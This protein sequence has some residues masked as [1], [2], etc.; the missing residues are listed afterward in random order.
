MAKQI[1]VDDMEGFIAALKYSQTLVNTANSGCSSTPVS[2]TSAE[3]T[4][5][6]NDQAP[7]TCTLQNEPDDDMHEVED[8]A[9]ESISDEAPGDG[10][11][12]NFTYENDDIE[13]AILR[14][15]ESKVKHGWSRDETLTQVRTI[16]ELTKDDRIPHKS[17]EAV[18]TFLKKLGYKRPKHYKVCCGATHVTLISEKDDCPDCG[19]E[20]HKCVDYFVLGLHL[21]DYFLNEETIRDHLEHWNKREEWLNKEELNVNVKEVWHGT[22]FRELSYFWDADVE[23]Y[24]PVYCPN[25]ETVISLKEMDDSVRPGLTLDS[26]VPLSYPQC[27]FDFIHIAETMKGCALNQ[28]FIF[29]EDG[30]NA[31]VQKSRGVAAIHI[32]SAC[33]SKEQRLRGKYMRV[34][35]FIPSFSLGEGIPH[36]IDAFFQPLINEVNEMYINGITVNITQPITIDSVT[37]INPGNYQVRLLLL[38]GTADLKGHQEITLYAG[39]KAFIL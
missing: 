22:R 7:S 18:L 20:W 19:K 27:A 21:E 34:Y 35:S 23:T 31:F 8:F 30:F 12:N 11:T 2:P 29:H 10:D 13:K 28:A 38:L 33:I 15:L 16:Y 32:S 4:E 17:W 25:C 6:Q 37:V 26:P 3:S 14:I 1:T 24:L 39:G 5:F 9:N 36:K